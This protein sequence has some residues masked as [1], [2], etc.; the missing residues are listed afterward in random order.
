MAPRELRPAWTSLRPRVI[1]MAAAVL[2]AAA[3][4]YAAAAEPFP[5]KGPVVDGGDGA[6]VVCPPG[7]AGRPTPHGNADLPGGPCRPPHHCGPCRPPHP[8]PDGPPDCD[9]PGSPEVGDVAVIKEDQNTGDVLAGAVFQ[10]WEETNG[11]PGLQTTGADPDTDIGQPCTTGTN[12]VCTRTM[13]YGTYY[14]WE[15]QAPPG[16]ELPVNPVFGPLVLSAE[17]AGEGVTVVAENAPEVD[18]PTRR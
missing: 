12:G 11:I 3:P 8:C 10:L 4:S 18:P 16:Y 9:G 5:G 17:T 15:T 13:P 14:W 1:G 7:H 6:G 2:L